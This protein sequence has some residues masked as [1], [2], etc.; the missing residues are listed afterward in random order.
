M[1]L[2]EYLVSKDDEEDY[3]FFY[4]HQPSIIIGKHQ[5]TIEEVNKDYV[6]EKQLY[7]ARRLSGGGA[8]YHDEGNLNFSFIMHASPSDINNF[9]KFTAPIIAALKKIGI[10]SELSGRNDILIDG[11]KFSGNAQFAKRNKILHHGTLLFDSKMDHLASA[12]NVKAMKIESKGVKSVKSRV[13]NIKPYLTQ[14]FTISEFR[15]HLIQSLD[16]TFGLEPYTLSSEEISHIENAVQEKFSTWDWNWGRSPAFD[17][18]K[19][20][21]FP[22]GIIDARLSITDGVVANCKFYGDFFVKRDIVNLEAHLKGIKYHE[23]ALLA[24]LE[25]IDLEDYFQGLS[26]EDLTVFLC[27]Q[28]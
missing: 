4:I 25:A 15:T 17:I 10:Y 21:K 2:E 13:T 9:G 11:K 5:N 27:S 7:V 20:S 12:L 26:A 1:A 14:A 24:A 23:A 8:V 18:Q 28:S 3:I 19:V 16:E 22:C 6:D